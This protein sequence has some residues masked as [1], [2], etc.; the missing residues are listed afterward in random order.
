MKAEQIIYSNTNSVSAEWIHFSNINSVSTE[1]L[2][3]LINKQPH[4]SDILDGGLE[5]EGRK[6]Y[7]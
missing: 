1:P 4:K 6:N 3:I 2:W 5:Q 7:M